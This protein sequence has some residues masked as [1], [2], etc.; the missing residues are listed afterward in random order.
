MWPDPV[1]NPGPLT[2][3]SGALPTALRGCVAEKYM[4]VHLTPF[5]NLWFSLL[6]TSVWDTSSNDTLSTRTMTI[7]MLSTLFWDLFHEMITFH[8]GWGKG[9]GAYDESIFD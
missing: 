9:R 4:A 7:F 8:L 2:Y 3:E 1:S 6:L 5:K